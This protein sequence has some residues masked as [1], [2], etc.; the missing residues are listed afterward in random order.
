MSLA[1]ITALTVV[2]FQALYVL[3]QYFTHFSVYVA[4][5][6]RNILIIHTHY[7]LVALGGSRLAEEAALRGKCQIV[8]FNSHALGEALLFLPILFIC[9][10]R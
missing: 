8:G 3:G 10:Q 1:Q 9:L 2:S 5:A 6:K 4:K 7:M